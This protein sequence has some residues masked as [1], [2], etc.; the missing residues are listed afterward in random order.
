MNIIFLIIGVTIVNFIVIDMIWTSLWVDKGAGILTR[1]LSN[2]T[3]NILV[4]LN[5]K[6]SGILNASGPIILMITLFSWV[7]ILWIGWAFV[8][9]SGS[10]D[11]VNSIT[12]NPMETID[13]IYYSG[14]VLFTLG[15][16]DFVPITGLMKILS[17]FS[18]GVGMLLL[19]IGASY[20]ISIVGA[21]VK[22][23]AFA[24]NVSSVGKS[25]Q[26]IIV[27]SW[28]GKNFQHMDSFL[29]S[30]S[31][32]LSTLTYQHKAYPLLYYYHTD[33]FNKALSV[34]IVKL[35]EVLTIL[36]HAVEYEKQPNSLLFIGMR[37]SIDNY[38]N[39]L[40]KMYIKSSDTPL[41]IPDLRILRE[42]NIPVKSIDDFNKEIKKIESR[43]KNL[44]GL[45]NYDN[46]DEDVIYS[47]KS[48]FSFK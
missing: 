8:F 23:R 32:E 22:K 4:R 12:G 39:I 3:W 16:G 28:N 1:N 48:K 33:D 21:V 6:K 17:T 41:S 43:R 27:N 47:N 40:N 10:K 25:P 46:W 11:I 26:D 34:A 18:T 36:E 24:I 45:L 20:I 2:I 19:T 35:D 44:R 29:I 37:S 31:S 9:A 7:L 15:N 13:I 5:T 42:K 30:L 38:L 14:Y